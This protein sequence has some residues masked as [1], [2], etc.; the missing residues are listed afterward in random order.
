MSLPIN[1]YS[2]SL[3]SV[4]ASGVQGNNLSRTV[5]F[6]HY[7]M[8]EDGR[9]VMFMTLADNFVGPGSDTNAD[10]DVYIKDMQTGDLRLI[11]GFGGHTGNSV[12][13]PTH[14][15]RRSTVWPVI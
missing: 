12:R 1:P 15:L 10:E 5:N 8:S 3:V 9:Y 14:I 11:S 7:L 4:T 2:I 6:G 13:P